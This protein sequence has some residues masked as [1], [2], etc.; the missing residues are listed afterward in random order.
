MGAIQCVFYSA[1]YRAEVRWS[2]FYVG[3]TPYA[4]ILHPNGVLC[5]KMLF[6]FL[7]LFVESVYHVEECEVWCHIVPGL[8]SAL[9]INRAAHV[10]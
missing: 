7:G 3:V 10:A 9:C 6:V 1:H 5:L 8:Y 2:M 4:N